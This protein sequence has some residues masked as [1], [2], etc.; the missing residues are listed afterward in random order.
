MLVGLMQLTAMV[1]DGH[2]RVNLQPGMLHTFPI[3]VVDVEGVPRVV[4]GAGPAANLVGGRLTRID[5]MPLAEAIAR[6]RTVIPQA[7]SEIL[8][9]ARTPQ[10]F[11][12]AEALH[13]LG[14]IKSPDAAR[15]T[16]VLDDGTEVSADLRWLDPASKPD[17]RLAAAK[18]PLSRQRMGEKFWFEWLPESGTVYVNFRS[19]ENLR[20][21]SRELWTFVDGHPVRKIAFDLRQNGGG[22]YTVGRRYLVDEL[23]RRPKVRGYVIT[24]ANTFSA[25]LKT[26]ID[27]DEVAGATLVGETIGEKANSYSENDEMVLPQSKLELSYS[28]RYYEFKRGVDLIRPD[29]E[30]LPTWADWVA[31]RDPVLEWIIEQEP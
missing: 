3:G 28:T 25:A 29:K 21:K 5:G 26:A 15:Y 9:A 17:W 31:G 2:T 1:G 27:F 22:D 30:I 19:Y 20:A 16:A 12:V 24:S 14:I 10:W 6:I 13:G 18:Q 4:R 8:I 7:E 11:S 23:A